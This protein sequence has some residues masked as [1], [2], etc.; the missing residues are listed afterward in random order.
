MV[1]DEGKQRPFLG[2]SGI[3]RLL[4]LYAHES[5]GHW[6]EVASDWDPYRSFVTTPVSILLVGS[7]KY[8]NHTFNSLA[9]NVRILL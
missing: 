6:I 4:Y 1:G 2:I 7:E 8:E 3:E 5:V 9:S